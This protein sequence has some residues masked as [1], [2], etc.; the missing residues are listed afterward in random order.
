MFT[1]LVLSDQTGRNQFLALAGVPKEVLDSASN[2]NVQLE[3]SLA[4]AQFDQSTKQLSRKVPDLVFFVE[5]GERL[6]YCLVVELK[7]FSRPG[8]ASLSAQMEQQADYARDIANHF[9]CPV[10]QVLIMLDP[11]EDLQRGCFKL[12]SWDDVIAC[13]KPSDSQAYRDLVRLPDLKYLVS[14]GADSFGKNC[15]NKLYGEDIIRMFRR[16][17]FQDFLIGRQGG[18]AKVVM[19]LSDGNFEIQQYETNS[20]LTTPPNRNWFWA[21]DLLQITDFM[22]ILTWG[23]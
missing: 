11:P 10:S 6:L 18:M 14:P 13:F 2:V 17:P 7:V 8:Q 23:D 9:G 16:I 5:N 12:M 4:K 1:G 22:N 15:E 21:T 3:F 20:K 19:E